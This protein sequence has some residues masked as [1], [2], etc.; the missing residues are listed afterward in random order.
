MS[1]NKYYINEKKYIIKINDKYVFYDNN[2]QK[3]ISI[4]YETENSL[5]TFDNIYLRLSHLD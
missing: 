4:Y 5:I 1:K 2:K 3:T